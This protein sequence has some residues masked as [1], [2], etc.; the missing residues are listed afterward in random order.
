[1][2]ILEQIG[3]EGQEKLLASKVLIVGAGETAVLTAKSLAQQG[4]ESVFVANRHYDKAID[5]AGRFGADARTGPQLDRYAVISLAGARGSGTLAG[6]LTWLHQL[7]LSGRDNP[8]VRRGAELAAGD[9]S[10]EVRAAAATFAG[11]LGDDR[12]LSALLADRD[13]SVRASAAL[14]AG[15]ADRKACTETVAALLQPTRTDQERVAAAYALGRLDP[16]RY[17]GQIGV[18]IGAAMA[19]GNMVHLDQLLCALGPLAKPEAVR[20]VQDVLD[21]CRRRKR[22]PPAMALVAAGELG[23]DQARPLIA[24]TIEEMIR[25]RDEMTMGEAMTL[26]AAVNAAGRLKM[27]AELFVKVISKLWHPGTSTAMILA[28]E[29]LAGHSP[30]V[31]DADVLALLRTASRDSRM[32]VPAAAA[33]VASHG[34]ASVTRVTGQTIRFRVRIT[35]RRAVRLAIRAIAAGSDAST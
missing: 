25:R 33:A 32:P 35:V 4:V 13:A 22:A 21:K 27:P 17:A 19:D 12:A 14:A 31:K 29:A 8:H 16:E 1:H 34:L 2:I 9:A 23:M 28:V 15:V 11:R 26:A 6:R 20:I 5:R 10:A 18:A 30:P 24:S 7:L 3:G